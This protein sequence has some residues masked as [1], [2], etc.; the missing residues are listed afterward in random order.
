FS[1]RGA[2]IDDIQ[3]RSAIEAVL[4][5][6]LSKLKAGVAA[7]E[8]IR[9]SRPQLSLR[10]FAPLARGLTVAGFV[11]SVAQEPSGTADR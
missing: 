9:A 7:L 5:E 3:E 10:K 1:Q 2:D 4:S 6:G 8:T 11:T